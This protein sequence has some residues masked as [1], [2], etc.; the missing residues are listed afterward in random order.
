MFRLGYFRAISREVEV[1]LYY[2]DNDSRLLGKRNCNFGAMN[3]NE[4]CN[5]TLYPSIYLLSVHLEAEEM[6][7]PRHVASIVPSI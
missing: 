2:I 1:P 6:Q 4:I 5:V 7:L 3:A